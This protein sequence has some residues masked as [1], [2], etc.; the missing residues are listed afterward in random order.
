MCPTQRRSIGFGQL[1]HVLFMIHTVAIFAPCANGQASAFGIASQISAM[2]SSESE[3]EA[4]G[5]SSCDSLDSSQDGGRESSSNDSIRS[6]E[7]DSCD[8]S[9]DSIRSSEDGGDESSSNRGQT[10][11]SEHDQSS[12]AKSCSEDTEGD[13]AM[14]SDDASAKDGSE[15][16]S[17]SLSDES[18]MSLWQDHVRQHGLHHGCSR[19]VFTRNKHRWKRQLVFETSSG[20]LASWLEE[21]SGVC[22]GAWAIG[23]KACRLA[24]LRNAWGRTRISGSN[25]QLGK[26]KRHEKS[27][28]HRRALATV[29]QMGEGDSVEVARLAITEDRHDVPSFAMCFAAYKGALQG[30]SFTQYTE[31]LKFAAMAGAKV[32]ES[33]RDRFCA[34]QLVEC[35]S[36]ELRS[37]DEALLRECTHIHLTSDGRKN[38]FVFRVRMTLKRLPEGYCRADGQASATD[39]DA[40]LRPLR[41]IS[42]KNFLRADR[43]LLF[44]RVS[45]HHT[46]CDLAGLLIDSLRQACNGDA[47]LWEAVRCKVYAF[48]PDGAHDEQLAGRL[49]TAAFPNLRA[50]LRC[51]A[52]ASRGQ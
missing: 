10:L 12:S 26:M 40:S 23:C 49:A 13:A 35:F 43:L 41:N 9:C 39:G 28:A 50:V 19:C 48:T 29:L 24:G 47:Q 44:H 32:P 4:L 34:R 22:S 46:T 16:G 2:A 20:S 15:E 45:G 18:D 5:S 38:N 36:A 8:D 1:C 51:S 21:R 33:R 3:D 14:S 27:E 6:S 52:H 17:S 11:C 42:G 37:E 7:D 30:N 31:D 25:V